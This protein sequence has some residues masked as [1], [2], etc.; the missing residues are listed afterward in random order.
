MFF[1]DRVVNAGD[2][3]YDSCR[4]NQFSS[5]SGSTQF[6]NERLSPSKIV[7]CSTVDQ[8]ISV[9]KWA[10]S[11]SYKVICRSGGHCYIGMGTDFPTIQIDLSGMKKFRV[12]GTKLIL[13]PGVKL[14]SISNQMILHKLS[15][16]HGLCKDVAVGGHLQ[17]SA[18]GILSAAAG[19]G[20][21]YIESFNIVLAN[22]E[23][24]TCRRNDDIY[25][26]VLGGPPGSFGIV[27]EFTLQCIPDIQY[28]HSEIIL[29][30][31]NYSKETLIEVLKLSI[32]IV[33]DQEERQVRDVVLYLD[34]GIL[35]SNL[36]YIPD[37]P[38]LKPISNF[39]ESCLPQS[40]T[41]MIDV[42]FLWSGADSGQMTE[43]WKNKYLSGYDKLHPLGLFESVTTKLPMSIIMSISS[44][45]YN[46]NLRYHNSGLLSTSFVSDEFFDQFGEY[47]DRR[48]QK[49]TDTL[50]P[51]TQISFD[52]DYS[53]LHLNPEAANSLPWRNIKVLI[54]DWTF[55]G[56][57]RD[58]DAI[59]TTMQ[60]FYDTFNESQVITPRRF[61]LPR[62]TVEN[63]TDLRNPTI[64]KCFYPDE[65]VLNFLHTV[66]RK[67]DSDDLF[68]SRGT[69]SPKLMMTDFSDCKL[70]FSNNTGFK[71]YTLRN[72][73]IILSNYHYSNNL[74][75][76][77]LVNSKLHYNGTATKQKIVFPSVLDGYYGPLT[78]RG[79]EI[80]NNSC[81]L[82]P[83]Q[84]ILILEHESF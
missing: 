79:G 82:V 9:T 38:V 78:I 43:F 47:Y 12:D 64:A 68:H 70:I 40:S 26:A 30:K 66:K 31:Y 29:R 59:K 3:D 44:S 18:L 36:D 77:Y 63:Y 52:H 62:T 50:Y 57:E 20:L 34:F 80:V 41:M 39:L 5:L 37:I 61:M 75:H 25:R 11:H 83:P 1:C 32:A 4:L 35:E 17:S 60:S 69:I 73:I 51:R 28:P 71:T 10:A 48:A 49:K 55:F 84:S 15:F 19:S 74:Y 16:P 6:V 42:M 54:D 21:D 24:R 7:Y 76:N 22:G 56:D 67:V 65:K 81:C 58:S 46:N 23:V 45:Y 53:Q 72:N 33:K 13:E 27:T 14:R 8:I 2:S